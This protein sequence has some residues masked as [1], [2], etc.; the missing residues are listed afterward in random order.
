M[1]RFLC[2]VLLAAL[3]PGQ[4]EAVE[5]APGDGEAAPPAAPAPESRHEVRLRS[6]T[7]L[8]GVIEPELWRI[9]TPFGELK[10]PAS[11][12]KKIRFGRRSAPQRS[13]EVDLW[14]EDLASVDPD[15]RGRAQA[16]LK[17]RVAF[18]ALALQRAAK[19]HADAEA[20]RLCAEI[21]EE[22]DLD[23]EAMVP[24]DDALETT[25][26]PIVGEVQLE[27]FK[28]TVPELGGLLVRRSEV[29]EVRAFKLVEFEHFTV[30]GNNMWPNGWVDTKMK[31]GKGE[32]LRVTAEGSIQF[33]NWGGHTFTP[34]GNPQMGNINGLPMGALAG[35]FGDGG[36]MFLVGR[37]WSGKAPNSGN[38][39]FCMIFNA[40]GQPSNGEFQ[41]KV[42]RQP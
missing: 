34:D 42:T 37:A 40:R 6:G 29:V 15:V 33:P 2:V 18:A 36:Q 20:R 31:V 7:V 10:V 28:V 24:E 4:E 5:E 16:A 8:V 1:R 21:L 9:A 41:I 32:A 22:A 30:S 17:E 11:E 19:D 26:H 14:I 35:R 38:L 12:I 25:K 23:P 13:A 27:T 39:Q 3:A